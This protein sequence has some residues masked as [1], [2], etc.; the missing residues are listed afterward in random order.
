MPSRP[1]QRR[2][3]PTLVPEV[4]DTI[5]ELMMGCNEIG[6]NS[7]SA[8]TGLVALLPAVAGYRAT[9][10]GASRVTTS[11]ARIAAAPVTWFDE[12]VS[13]SHTDATTIAMTGVR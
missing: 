7:R 2:F 10:E 13:P 3:A 5:L 9:G 8:E 6:L 12:I 1:A 11:P 4:S